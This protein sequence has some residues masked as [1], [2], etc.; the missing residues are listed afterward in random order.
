VEIELA[1]ES[2]SS[3]G[4]G[5]GRGPDGRVVFVPLTA[6]GDRVRALVTREHKR[7]LRAEL[8][9]LIE[10]A[11]GRV[12]P[13]C[14]VFGDCGGCTWQHLDYPAQLAAKREILAQALRR[15]GGLALPE[16]LEIEASPARYG[17]RGRSRV[18]AERG[19]VGYR[20]RASRELCGIEHCAVLEPELDAALAALAHSHPADG[21][22]ELARGEAGARASALGVLRAPRSR[23]APP[24]RCVWTIAG[25]RFAFSPGVFTQANPSLCG[26]LVDA[27]H[28][29]A[30]AG[31]SALDAYCGAGLFTLGL[32]K[33]FERVTA[34]EANADAISD[35]RENL[36]TARAA[37]V[38]VVE[39]RFEHWLALH[40]DRQPRFDTA[41]VDPPRSGLPEGGAAAL[42]QLARRRIVY[43][44]CDPATLAR[45]LAV[46]GKRDFRLTQVRG[47]DLFPQTPHVE[48]LAVLER[49]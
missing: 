15:I 3:S 40:D 9:E 18:H 43:V 5:V 39:A 27:V 12:T 32:A 45:D 24:E 26:V 38:D 44:S 10:S 33:R 41:V 2:L 31:R 29:A 11:P 8:R 35:L 16:Q 22:W 14:P 48:A 36:A 37:N 13:R 42:A 47:F 46:L 21:E 20:K 30:G 49:G 6:P 7:F 19:R 23:S 34:V 1:I 25:D 17:Y 4:D 28:A